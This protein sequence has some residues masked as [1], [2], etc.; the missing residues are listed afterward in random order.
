M[1]PRPLTMSPTDW[2]MLIGL[3][4][5][6]GGAFFL[7]KV[8]LSEL[9]PLTVAFARVG[10]AAIILLVIAWARNELRP[11][12]PACFLILGLVNSA[13]PLR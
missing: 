8:A 1:T 6:W 4:I 13:S 10:L 9:P 7:N 3:S 2:L 11:I 5:L 12:G